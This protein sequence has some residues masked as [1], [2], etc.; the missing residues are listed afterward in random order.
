MPESK[1]F[2]PD[3]LEIKTGLILPNNDFNFL[4]I[5][6]PPGKNT[7]LRRHWRVGLSVP[8]SSYRWPGLSPG[9]TYSSGTTSEPTTIT[10]LC[11]N[12]SYF[13]AKKTFTW[14]F[15]FCKLMTICSLAI[16]ITL[17][18]TMLKANTLLLC[19]YSYTVCTSKLYA[20]TI[21]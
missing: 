11:L 3:I 16:S 9:A 20:I 18:A 1:N 14:F 4:N 10:H 5:K 21:K 8:V 7:F 12:S 6:S 19:C 17:V 2:N 15:F 13:K